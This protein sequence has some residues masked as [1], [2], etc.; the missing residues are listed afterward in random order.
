LIA[1]GAK[2]TAPGSCNSIVRV[3]L[4]CRRWLFH[5]HLHDGFAGI[6]K[7]PVRDLFSAHGLR[8]P[9]GYTVLPMRHFTT[10]KT[11][12]IAMGG[13]GNCKPPHR[14]SAP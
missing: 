4:H 13:R 1:V 6:K 14:Q 11:V 10:T 9:D 12:A 2:V 5:R 3:M 7:G 8:L